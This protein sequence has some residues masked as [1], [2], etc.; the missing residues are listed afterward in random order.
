[1]TTLEPRTNFHVI[2]PFNLPHPGSV[3][4]A[5]PRCLADAVRAAVDA[6]DERT[7]RPV[8][9]CDAALGFQ[10]KALLALL[11]Y[12]YS[13]EIYGSADIENRLLR[14]LDF[15]RL[16]QNRLPDAAVIRRFRRENREA[17]QSCL[18]ATLRFQV[19]QKVKAGFVTKVN[20]AQFA[21]EANR[22]MIM[23]MFT[24]SMQM[25]GE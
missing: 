10:P 12:C 24:D 16:C 5:E 6:V 2:E 3:T 7:L 9:P 23:A 1:M 22:R 15:C 25:D 14:D 17:I 19:Q 20:I 18:T 4:T 11:S 21:A 8:A 13:R